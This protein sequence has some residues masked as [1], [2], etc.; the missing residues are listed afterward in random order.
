VSRTGALAASYHLLR[1]ALNQTAATERDDIGYLR[2]QRVVIRT[3][4]PQKV[5][6]DGGIIGTTPIDVECVP[7]D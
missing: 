4:P 6:L 5:V 7:G 1:T 2:A 3:D